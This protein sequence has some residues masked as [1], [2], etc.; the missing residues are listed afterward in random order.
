M[1]KSAIAGTPDKATAKE[2]SAQRGRHQSQSGRIERSRHEV[3]SAAEP[4][5]NPEMNFLPQ[6]QVGAVP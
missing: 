1:G 6:S 3:H 2:T 5:P 4:Q